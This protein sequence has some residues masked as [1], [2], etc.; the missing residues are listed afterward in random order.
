[1]YEIIAMNFSTGNKFLVKTL[2]EFDEIVP[3]MLRL[4]HENPHL[5][6]S[7][8]SKDDTDRDKIQHRR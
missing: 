3:E 1:M 4:M 2:K 6:Y 5:R 7:W 8:R